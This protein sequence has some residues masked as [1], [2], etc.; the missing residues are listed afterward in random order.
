MEKNKCAAPYPTPSRASPPRMGLKPN[1]FNP[2]LKVALSRAVRLPANQFIIKPLFPLTS[3]PRSLYIRINPSPSLSVRTAAVLNL[4][5]LFFRHFHAPA[6]TEFPKEWND[7]RSATNK[8]RTRYPYSRGEEEGRKKSLA[9]NQTQ[10][11]RGLCRFAAI[12]FGFFF[13]GG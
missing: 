8:K 1:I 5:S 2:W 7:S 6:E 13:E 10:E 9:I 3:F 4:I 11:Y 12:A